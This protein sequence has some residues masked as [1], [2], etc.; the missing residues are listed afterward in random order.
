MCPY[1][2]YQLLLWVCTSRRGVGVLSTAPPK[3]VCDVAPAATL[4]TWLRPF[5]L[6]STKRLAFG[7]PLL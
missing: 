4:G 3:P 1:R 6:Y 7:A 5:L 2:V